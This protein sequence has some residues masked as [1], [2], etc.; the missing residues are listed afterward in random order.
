MMCT[1]W[2]EIHFINYTSIYSPLNGTA[3]YVIPPKLISSAQTAG[4][5]YHCMFRD[6]SSGY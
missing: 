4:M 6:D 1:M 3:V 2:K 5:G